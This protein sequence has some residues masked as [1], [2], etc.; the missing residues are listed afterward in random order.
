VFLSSAV[1]FRKHPQHPNKYF[2]KYRLMTPVTAA[3]LITSLLAHQSFCG[4]RHMGADEE[5]GRGGPV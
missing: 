2:I 5:V 1:V 3:L 4:K